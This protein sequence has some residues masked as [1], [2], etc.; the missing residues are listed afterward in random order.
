MLSRFAFLK[1]MYPKKYNSRKSKEEDLRKQEERSGKIGMRKIHRR[2]QWNDSNNDTHLAEGSFF[3]QELCQLLLDHVH[4]WLYSSSI[5]ANSTS[6]HGSR[7]PVVS[8][9]DVVAADVVRCRQG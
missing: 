7:A 8:A 2:Y 4:R 1:R 9:V 6:P 3:S 5:T